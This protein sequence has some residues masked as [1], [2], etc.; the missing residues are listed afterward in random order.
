M[1]PFSRT[2]DLKLSRSYAAFMYSNAKSSRTFWL[3][4]NGLGVHDSLQENYA[5]ELL[6]VMRPIMG[7]LPR[8][9]VLPFFRQSSTLIF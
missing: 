2:S 7:A 6:R 1:P 9:S 5:F 3:Y 8:L 4:G